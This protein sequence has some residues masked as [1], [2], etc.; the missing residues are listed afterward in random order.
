VEFQQ[1]KFN[2]AEAHYRKALEIN[3][4]SAFAHAHLGEAF[5][6]RKDKETARTH[7]KTALKLDPLGDFGKMAR[8]L[9]EMADRVSFV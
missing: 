5:L 3:P 9:M 1:G 8:R 2:D 6:F 4:R 7:F